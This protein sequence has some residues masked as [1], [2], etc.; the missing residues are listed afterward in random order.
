MEELMLRE[1]YCDV[2][3]K[4]EDKDYVG[5]KAIFGIRSPVFMNMFKYQM[6]ENITGVVDID[7]CDAV[8]F[9]EFMRY[10]Y[11]SRVSKTFPRVLFPLYHVA[12][13]YQVVD[14]KAYCIEQIKSIICVE[15]FS[16]C[17]ELC[18]QY[19][20]EHFMDIVTEFLAENMSE[21]RKSEEWKNFD[22]ENPEEADTL[23][24]KALK[25]QKLTAKSKK[26]FLQKVVKLIIGGK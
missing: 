11:A 18:F 12:D 10:I 6:S 14:L 15:N 5:H 9:R 3:I 21:I 2:T 1:D 16:N 24:Q 25:Y 23:L 26:T 7:D 4:V 13:K 19:N 22:S 8:V 17:A 20:D